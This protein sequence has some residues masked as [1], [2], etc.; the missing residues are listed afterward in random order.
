M[1]A[2]HG[3]VPPPEDEL[4]AGVHLGRAR[5]LYQ[6]P[7]FGLRQLVD[8]AIQA[9]SPA[10][11]QPTTA[12]QVVDRLEDILLRVAHRPEP[13]GLF[14]DGPGVVRLV[15]RV[16]TFAGL[17]ELAFTEITADG[18]SSPQ[19][20]RRLLAAYDD[21]GPAVHERLRP[22]IE[23]RRPATLASIQKVAVEGIRSL[24]QRPD[25]TGLG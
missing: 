2:V 19:V 5:T 10:L 12:G 20:A 6:D 14:T 17:L 4:L 7:S 18:A 9:L 16:P 25:R 11:N 1:F 24:A 13:T 21:L 22:S 23:Q 15:Q 3:P 8:V